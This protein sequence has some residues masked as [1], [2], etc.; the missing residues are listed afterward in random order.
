MEEP[1]TLIPCLHSFCGPCFTKVSKKEK[2]CPSCRADVYY[3]K[4]DK[5]LGKVIEK[6]LKVKPDKNRGVE[7]EQENIFR[8]KDL[9]SFEEI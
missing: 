6:A 5:K 3:A 8:G 7:D 1:V 9:V 2:I 4:N